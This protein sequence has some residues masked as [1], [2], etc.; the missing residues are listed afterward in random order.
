VRAAGA[1]AAAQAENIAAE[2]M[3]PEMVV[4]SRHRGSAFLVRAAGA[5]VAVHTAVAAAQ[6]ENIGAEE[7]DPEPDTPARV[8]VPALLD[9]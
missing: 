2:A 7:M 5:V 4:Q 3:S 8:E 6:A 9:E 1:A